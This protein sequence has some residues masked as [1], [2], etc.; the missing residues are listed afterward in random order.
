MTIMDPAA[1]LGLGDS[2][3]IAPIAAEAR[4]RLEQALTVLQAPA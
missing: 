1:A 3:A 4:T 2:R